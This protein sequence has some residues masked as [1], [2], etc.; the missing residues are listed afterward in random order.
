MTRTHV[1]FLTATLVAI[2][3]ACT[4]QQKADQSDGGAATGGNGGSAGIGGSAGAAGSAGADGGVCAGGVTSEGT[5]NGTV[6]TFCDDAGA[7]QTVDCAQISDTCEVTNG[8]AD[9]VAPTRAS[10]CGSLDALGTCDGAVLKYCD[11]TGLSSVPREIDCAAYGQLCDPTGASDGGAICVPQGPCPSGLDQNGTCNGNSLSFCEGGDEFTFDCGV[12]QCQSVGGF[13]DCFVVGASNGC[14]TETAAGRCDA[15]GK[16]VSCQGNVVATEDCKFLGMECRADGQGGNRCMP[17]TSCSVAC[18]SGMAC[19]SG[20]CTATQTPSADWTFL[21]YVVGDNSLTADA[22]DDLNEM[23]TVGSTSAVNVVSEVE[24]STD[25]NYGP[26]QPY[27]NAVWRMKMQKDSD[28][29]SVTS[30][31]TAEKAG[32]FKMSDP[33]R[34]SEFIRWGVEQYPAKHYALVM[35]NHGAGYKE[36]FIDNAGALSLKDLVSGI[37]GSGV[38][39]DLVGYDACF[40]GMHEVAYSMRGLADV[41]VGSEQTE[42]GGGY[43]YDLVLGHLTAQPTMTAAQLGTHIVD[44]YAQS[45]SSGGKVSSVT[46]SAVD[47]TKVEALHEKIGDFVGGL[48]Q[49]LP[50]N[51]S[52]ALS[53]ADSSDVLRFSQSE[54]AD[55]GTVVSKFHDLGPNA[56]TAATDLSGTLSSSGVIIDS[57]ATGSLTAAT[58][59]AIF[60]AQPSGGYYGGSG[61]LDGYMSR[62]DF[63]P[64]QPWESFSQALT[65]DSSAAPQPGTGAVDTFRVVLT[66]GDSETS[67]SSNSDLDLY[68]FEPNGDFGTPANGSTTENGR[69]SGD[70]YDTDI[71]QESYELN[72]SHE[73][74]TYVVLVNFYGGPTGEVAYPTLQVFRPDLPGGSRTLLRAKVQNHQLVQIPMDNSTPL[75]QPIDASNFQGVLDMDYS[76]LWYVTTIDVK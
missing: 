44:D 35:W 73:T 18:P 60:L 31:K 14:G 6:V 17:P 53:Y 59:L 23:E 48:A 26:E 25:Y 22:W 37:H 19:Q 36:A 20:R 45:Y 21:V 58:G 7:V 29:S 54:D 57:K 3:P 67:T 12:D 41:M 40:M 11:A 27:L 75:N 16:R 30:L 8:R 55:L 28:T 15:S 13:A 61:A 10:S 34:V 76:N 65:D 69:L 33:T 72:P 42:P 62:V 9:C 32:T 49:D 43:P 51:R 71:P 24:F 50:G 56:G 1:A 4:I 47:L 64:M 70:S 46:N 38:H 39:L 52:T 5:C 66:W 63:L 68:V 2:A 74:G